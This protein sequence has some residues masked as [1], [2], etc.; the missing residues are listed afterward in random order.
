[1]A[2]VKYY[3]VSTDMPDQFQ[4]P[5]LVA[6]EGDEALWQ[7]VRTFRFE[8]WHRSL[9]VSVTDPRPWDPTR[10][11]WISSAFNSTSPF[12]CNETFQVTFFAQLKSSGCSLECCQRGG[13]GNA[14]EDKFSRK[15]C[16][17]CGGHAS[18]F[19]HRRVLTRTA[20]SALGAGR[21]EGN[22]RLQLFL[23]CVEC[24]GPSA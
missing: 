16:T 20:E 2:A 14:I 12:G 11:M 15:S 4:H 22:P 5:L 17:K 6:I 18:S 19:C 9:L 1:M 24:R 7:S 23:L 3:L 13:A 21:L 8:S 10:T